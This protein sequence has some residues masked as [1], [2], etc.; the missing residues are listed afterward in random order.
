MFACLS[1]CEG[2]RNR[3]I[4]MY[5]SRRF[6]SG[7]EEGGKWE[8]KYAT[9]VKCHV[10]L[11]DMEHPDQRNEVL[12]FSNAA[13]WSSLHQFLRCLSTLLRFVIQKFDKT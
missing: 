5:L 2:M 13:K 1:M 7:V 11:H 10:N 6:R 12:F 9:G 8:Q 4:A 3:A